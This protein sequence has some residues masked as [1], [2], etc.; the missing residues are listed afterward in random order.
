[1]APLLG[2]PTL[3][4]PNA[5]LAFY[6]LRPFAAKIAPGTDPR[7]EAL[8]RFG[9]AAPP[10]R[11]S[12]AGGPPV[13][14]AEGAV[15]LR[16]R[17]MSKKI[18][19]VLPSYNE[20]DN[21]AVL[22]PEILAVLSGLDRDYEVLVVDD[23]STDGTRAFIRTF[24]V[25]E[26]RCLRLRRNS[27]K[28]AALSIG[29]SNADGDV[30]AVMDADGQ[31]DPR[32]LPRLLDALD[33]P[34]DLVTGRRAARHDRFVKRATSKLYNSVTRVVTGVEGRDFN[35]GF[36][37]MT[38]ELARNLHLYGELHR[39]I[40]VLAAWQG[41]AITEVDVDHR[42]RFSG[43]SKFGIVRFWRG[44]LDLM[45]VKF[46]VQYRTRPFHLFGG[47]GIGL[48]AIGGGV[49]LWMAITKLNGSPIGERPA[50]I[51]G[52]LLVVVSVQMLSLGLIAELVV[53]L[54]RRRNLDE[55]I[56]VD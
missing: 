14:P 13:R 16:L 55:V 4:S 53:N 46:L 26:V 6:D 31:D 18:S 3:V 50:L 15:Q 5:R 44:L 12:R 48:G 11:L 22:I 23:G 7:A 47:L 35:S 45:T 17:A 25:P 20:R 38:A 42:P 36:K 49:L 52:V 30:V 19:I 40:P 10:A 27:G 8:A 54:H 2:P 32:E 51:L 28:S 41:F 29:L 39:Y 56:E 9:V 33:G 34:F 43:S 21:L 37:V 1:M 24:G